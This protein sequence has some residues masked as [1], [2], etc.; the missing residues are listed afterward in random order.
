MQF[1][2]Q[3]TAII[4]VI[5][6]E[7]KY[8]T[9]RVQKNPGFFL[10]KPNLGGFFL[11]FIRFYWVLGFIGFFGRAVPAAVSKHGKGK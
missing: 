11:G 3:I 5:F 10:K 6:S 4:C 7:D 9:S 2:T 1:K 8:T